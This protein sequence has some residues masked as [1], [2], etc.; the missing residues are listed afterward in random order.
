MLSY[1]KLTVVPYIYHNGPANDPWTISELYLDHNHFNVLPV[2]YF[3]FFDVDSLKVLH[4]GNVGMN[5]RN[6]DLSMLQQL[7]ILHLFEV[8]TPDLTGELPFSSCQ[9]HSNRFLYFY[10]F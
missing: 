2:N 5:I 3:A 4:L 9:F 10:D 1:N 6:N 7:R 8:A